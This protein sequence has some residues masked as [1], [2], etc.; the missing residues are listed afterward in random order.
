VSKGHAVRNY[1]YDEAVAQV[2]EFL[3]SYDVPVD[4]SLPLA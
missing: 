1:R 3:A 2:D 4:A